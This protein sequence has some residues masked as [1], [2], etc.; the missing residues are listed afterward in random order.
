MIKNTLTGIALAAV[1][2]IGVAAPMAQAQTDRFLD[3]SPD[4]RARMQVECGPMPNAHL[5]AT[6]M[7]TIA[8]E[9]DRRSTGLR[10]GLAETIGVKPRDIRAVTRRHIERCA[11]AYRSARRH[12]HD[13]AVIDQHHRLGGIRGQRE[14]R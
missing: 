11:D 3:L 12:M 2:A 13:W 10:D 1:C 5:R 6:C 7:D 14:R 8:I 4:A 9:A